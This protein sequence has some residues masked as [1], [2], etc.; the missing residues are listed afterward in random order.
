MRAARRQDGPPPGDVRPRPRTTSAD[1]P[2]N[3]GG[4]R[5]RR[6]ITRTALTVALV[7]SIGVS[8]TGALAAPELTFVV[9]DPSDR[10]DVSVGNGICRTS[11][12]TCTL[13]AATQEANAHAGSD[14]IQILP[15]TYAITIAPINENAANVG[16]FEILDPVTIEKAPGYLDERAFAFDGE[17]GRALEQGD[18]EAL[19]R[20]D[21]GL[22]EELMVLGRPA[23]AV[24]GEAVAGQGAR[25]RARVLYSDDPYGVQY[26]VAVWELS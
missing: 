10:V 9:D 8:L 12:G 14:V 16:D 26:T 5:P 24:L 21:P 18:A 3:P 15:G 7:F 20:L 23:F 6:G 19:A 17:T 13:R 2:S 11:T 25:A 4:R 22:G 1:A